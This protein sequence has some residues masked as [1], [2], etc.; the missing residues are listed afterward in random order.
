MTEHSSGDAVLGP[1]RYGKA[2]TR[3]VHIDRRADGDVLTDLN[4]SIA[5]SGD[6]TDSHLKGDNAHVLP[7]DTQKNTVYA[8]ARDGVGAPETFAMRLARHFVATQAPI[9]AAVVDV[10][11]FGWERLAAHSF[12]RAGTEV[13]TARVEHDARGTLVVSGLRDLVVLNTTDSEFAGFATD[14]YT[15]LA[16]TADRV[17]ATA[18]DARWRC[19]AEAEADADADGWDGRYVRVRDCLLA[20]FTGTY[21]WAL[22]QTLF[23]MGARV[24]A[25][26]PE[27]V[28]VRLAL[29]NRHHVLVDLTPFGL[30]N[31]NAVYSAPDRPYGLIEAAVLRAGTVADPRP[32]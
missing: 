14:R 24:I 23:A 28:E 4:V 20:A 22:Q 7:T 25:E 21:S 18:I 30:D 17:L 8:F 2:E 29:P 10:K 5:L 19:A 15:T 27:V 9:T 3:V 32:W 11:G 16:P 6:L 1:N 26:V 12:R 13:R 31:P